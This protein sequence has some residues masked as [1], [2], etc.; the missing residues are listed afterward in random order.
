MQVKFKYLNTALQ[1]ILMWIANFRIF[2]KNCLLAPRCVKFKVKDF[3]YLIN[4]WKEKNSFYYTELHILQGKM[5]DKKNFVRDLKRETTI[6]KI[7]QKGAYIFTLNKE[8]LEKEYYLPAFNPKIIQVRPV[9]ERLDGY[10]DWVLASWEK[11]VL[12]EITKIPVFEV[13][14]KSI[15]K[16]KI[17]EIFMPHIYPK[18]SPKQ[19]SALRLA[20]DH[21]YYEYPRN[22]ELEK[23]ARMEHVRRQTFQEHLR[24]AERKLIPFLAENIGLD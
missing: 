12:L 1:D 22:I 14:I 9:V 19:R 17:A 8:P 4:S 16:I 3:V 7:E 6:K 24:R 15:R 11:D 21:G 2:H 23:L 5:E 10:E 18:L 20:V 13:E